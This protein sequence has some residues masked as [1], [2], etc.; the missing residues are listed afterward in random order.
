MNSDWIFVEDSG[1]ERVYC[2]NTVLGPIEETSA[3]TEELTMVS[4]DT[5]DF[6]GLN[7][8]D[9]EMTGYLADCEIYGRD[10]SSGWSLIKDEQMQLWVSY[11][12]HGNHNVLTNIQALAGR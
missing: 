6:I 12:G 7:S 11:L 4:M 2:Y 3:L 9:F 1:A 10:V 5:A 8:V